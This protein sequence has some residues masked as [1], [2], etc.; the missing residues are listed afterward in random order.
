MAK[1]ANC[2]REVP[3]GL[4]QCPDCLYPLGQPAGAPPPPSGYEHPPPPYEAYA[5]YGGWGSEGGDPTAVAPPSAGDRPSAGPSA[6]P[7]SAYGPQ[8][9]AAPAGWYP[10]GNPY[11]PYR[12]STNGLAIASLVCSIAGLFTCGIGA[13]LGVIFGHIAL[14]QVKQSGEEGR[15]LALAGVIVGWVFIGLVAAYFI[16]L[17]VARS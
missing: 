7:P 1:C 13:I 2:G 8:P 6:P 14:G 5:G 4:T 10:T 12:Q 15:G 9:A 16:F 17:A 11:M 3:E